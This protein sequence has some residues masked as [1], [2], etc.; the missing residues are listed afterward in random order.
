MINMLKTLK[1][2]KRV[3][4]ISEL[5][6]NVSKEIEILRKK[7]KEMLRTKNTVTERKNYFDG[8]IST[9]HN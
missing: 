7:Q 4:A 5:I 2:K 9:G 3:D 1:K 6:G 8:Q